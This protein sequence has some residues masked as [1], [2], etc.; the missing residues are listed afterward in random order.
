MARPEDIKNSFNMTVN[1]SHSYLIKKTR[2]PVTDSCYEPTRSIITIFKLSSFN[3][4]IY[5][6]HS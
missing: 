5:S 2:A 6:R 1:N 4:I 3:N